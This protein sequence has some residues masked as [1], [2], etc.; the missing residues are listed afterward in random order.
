M[1]QEI[2]AIDLLPP[3][4]KQSLISNI[5]SPTREKKE[6]CGMTVLIDEAKNVIDR[7]VSVRSVRSAII[8][9][10]MIGHVRT[11]ATCLITK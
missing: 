2:D 11:G 10:V 9:H 3:H 7:N 1:L 4:R 6:S 5:I 8:V